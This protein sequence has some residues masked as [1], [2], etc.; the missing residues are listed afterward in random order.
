MPAPVFYRNEPQNN[1]RR[2]CLREVLLQRMFD[3]ANHIMKTVLSIMAVLSIGSA[4]VLFVVT[5]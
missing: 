3:V 5:A 2:C 1:L 4:M